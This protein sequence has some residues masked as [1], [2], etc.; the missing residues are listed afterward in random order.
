MESKDNSNEK[1]STIPDTRQSMNYCEREKLKSFAYSCERLGDTESLVC[2]LIMITHW[3]RQSK[4]CQ[5]NEFASQWTKAQK[6]IEKFGKS[7]KAMQ[8]TWPL[9]GKP[10]MK[11]GKCYYRDHQN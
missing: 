4:K 2:A 11:K 3:F 10:K 5:F 8:D 7:T 9:S 6:D 1:L